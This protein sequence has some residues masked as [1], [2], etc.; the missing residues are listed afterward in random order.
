MVKNQRPAEHRI[1][2]HGPHAAAMASSIFSRIL[3]GVDNSPM[4]TEAVR[5]A[6]RLAHEHGG[7]LVLFHAV[8]WYRA[9]AGADAAMPFDATPIIDALSDEGSALLQEAVKTAKACGTEA[10]VRMIDGDPARQL[11]EAATA[12]KATLAVLGTHGR[13]GIGRMFVGSTA[14]AVLRASTIPVM[15]VRGAPWPIQEGPHGF[16]RVLLA[17]DDS[18]PSDAALEAVLRMP[19]DPQRQLLVC[20]ALVPY[21]FAAGPAGSVTIENCRYAQAQ[22]IV[23]R[24]VERANEAGVPAKGSILDGRPDDTIV[25]RAIDQGADLI[26]VGSH[27]RRGVQRFFLGSVAE[28]IVRTATVPVLVIRPS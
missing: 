12:E 10:V 18:E 26:V 17:V 7:A 23:D 28:H 20:H 11:L 15:T 8:D 5:L 25:A 19:A 27:G 4:S 14:E 2:T 1:F 22:T 13:N 6:A 3:A 24:A 9:V 16:R 21:A